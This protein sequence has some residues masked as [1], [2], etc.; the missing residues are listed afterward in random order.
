MRGRPSRLLVLLLLLAIPLAHGLVAL[1]CAAHAGRLAQLVQALE[2]AEDPIYELLCFESKFAAKDKTLSPMVNRLILD[3]PSLE[4]AVVEMT[5][6]KLGTPFVGATELSTLMTKMFKSAQGSTIIQSVRMDLLA[7]AMKEPSGSDALSVFLFHKG[8]ISLT[9]HRLAHWLWGQGRKYLA[10]YLQSVTSEEFT[11][12][13][14]PAA[15]IGQEVYIANGAAVVIGETSVVGDG[16]CIMHGVTLGGTGKEQGDRHPKV[17]KGCLI[18]SGSA[19]LGNIH[20]GEGSRI[21]ACSVVVKPVQPY[22]INKGV[23]AKQT[24][25]FTCDVEESVEH[26][27]CP[28]VAAAGAEQ[29]LSNDEPRRMM[30]VS[31]KMIYHGI[32]I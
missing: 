27:K 7:A 28:E 14:H 16:V 4:K 21:Q 25:W 19:L 24:G 30:F 13:V 26:I 29:S 31:S 9:G 22:S 2:N 17:G 5:S 11:V 10:R 3:Q 1:P 23:P 12:D 8:F 18:G 32:G 15:Q 20:I 6:N